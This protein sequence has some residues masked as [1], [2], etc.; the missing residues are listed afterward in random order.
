[1]KFKRDGTSEPVSEGRVREIVDELL[2]SAFRDYSRDLE[3]HLKDIHERLEN[4]E[5]KGQ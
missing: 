1:M 5:K 2:R 4:I 3:K